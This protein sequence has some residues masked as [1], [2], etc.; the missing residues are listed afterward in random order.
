MPR[1]SNI[2][3]VVKHPLH[4]NRGIM[5]LKIPK[6]VDKT[7]LDIASRLILL[8][9]QKQAGDSNLS[10][11]TI[12]KFVEEEGTGNVSIK[13][14]RIYSNAVLKRLASA[15]SSLASSE[16]F[17]RKK[18]VK[19]AKTFIMYLFLDEQIIEEIKGAMQRV[20]KPGSIA[21]I[22]NISMAKTSVE[23]FLNSRYDIVQ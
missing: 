7:L 19:N 23:F 9:I 15:F 17:P 13:L 16:L 8:E 5:I 2:F 10:E 18:G 12:M 21:E 3:S 20:E 4:G 22:I 6:N 14:N 1:K 11:A